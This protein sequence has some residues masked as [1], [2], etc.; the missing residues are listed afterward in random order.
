M[1]FAHIMA[2]FMIFDT[3]VIG[4]F[5]YRLIGFSDLLKLK[6]QIAP[7]EKKQK[8][9]KKTKKSRRVEENKEDIESNIKNEEPTIQEESVNLSISSEDSEGSLVRKDEV[10]PEQIP[11]AQ[12]VHIAPQNFTSAPQL[13]RIGDKTYIAV[14][15]TD[16]QNFNQCPQNFIT[17]ERGHNSYM[18]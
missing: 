17:F 15:A 10:V 14:K 5:I 16:I 18:F 3:V 6:E 13:I 8:K 7:A 9:T 11:Q 1:C 4:I 12:P 2:I